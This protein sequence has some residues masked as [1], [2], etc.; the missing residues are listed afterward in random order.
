MNEN[1]PNLA[2]LKKLDL[3]D[4]EKSA[5]LFSDDVIWHYFNPHLPELQGDYVGLRGIQSFFKKVGTLSNGT[6]HVEP[7]SGVAV[8]G[9]LVVVQ[10]RNTLLID[11]QHISLD[12]V[13][14]WRI[15]D[16]Q[17]TEVWDI[18]PIMATPV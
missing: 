9:E 2:L 7:I 16:G 6:F 10:T 14:V 11:G 3:R 4:L 18:V 13:L 17:I 12:V 15:V 8:G 5:E 1:H